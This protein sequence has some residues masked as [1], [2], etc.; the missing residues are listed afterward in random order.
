MTKE[1]LYH[2]S[3]SFMNHLYNSN[4]AYFLTDILLANKTQYIQ[5]ATYYLPSCGFFAFCYAV[6]FHGAP[7]QPILKS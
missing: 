6:A 7:I 3:C 5:N 4:F 1:F 2:Q